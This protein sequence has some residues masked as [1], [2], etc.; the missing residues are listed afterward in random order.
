VIDGIQD[1]FQTLFTGNNYLLPLLGTILGLIIGAM[2][3]LGPAAGIALIIPITYGWEPEQAFLLMASMIG[4][5]SFAGSITAILVNTPGESSNAAT[6]LDGYPMAKNGQ[7]STAL[8][9]SAVSSAVGAIFG[10]AV[11]VAVLPVSRAM[12]LKIS[13][14]E[15]FVIGVVGLFI[16][17]LISR[18]SLVKGMIA[19]GLGF[20][21]SF[22]GRDLITGEAR[23]TFGSLFLEDGIDYIAILIGLFALSEAIALLVEPDVP[24]E[25]RKLGLRAHWRQ[26]G[27]GVRVCRRYPRILL[28]SSAIGTLCGIIPGVGGSVSSFM[29]YA[30]AK[31]SAKDPEK[32]GTGDPRGVLAS[33][34]ANDAKDGGALI[35]TVALGLPGS[36]VWAVILGAFLVHGIAPGQEMLT[37]HLD[38]VFLIILGLLISNVLTSAFGLALSPML[39]P[40]A[41]MPGVY[42]SPVIFVIALLGAYTIGLRP[43]DIIIAMLAGILGFVLKR[44]GFSLVPIVIGM[45]LGQIVERSLGQTMLTLGPTAFFTRPISLSVLLLGAIAFSLPLLRKRRSRRG[46]SAADR[47]EKD[48]AAR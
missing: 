18:G 21:L 27:D 12:I 30:A 48:E 39:A 2:P 29:A 31:Q 44:Q 46:S 15:T 32:F 40:I 20:M 13:Y 10:L 38:V 3:G 19:G 25:Q 41:K 47:T 42:V 26:I 6:L 14:P 33:E 23:Y 17:A 16:I 22:V 37:Q 4:G 5:T 35:P 45:I 8:S 36:P 9:I 34:A 28:Q 43:G 1:A 11:F 7:A 24:A